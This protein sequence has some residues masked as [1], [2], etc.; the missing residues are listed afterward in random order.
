MG[1]P[2]D[3]RPNRPQQPTIRRGPEPL[4]AEVEAVRWN[5]LDERPLTASS[6]DVERLAQG[7]ERLH[8]TWNVWYRDLLIGYEDEVRNAIAAVQTYLEAD[9]P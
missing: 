6:A 7:L 2:D 1:L 9:G 3:L 5:D 8:I 4:L